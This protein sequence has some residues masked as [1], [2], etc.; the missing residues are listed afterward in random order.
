MTEPVQK[1]GNRLS[2]MEY[3]EISLVTRG[4]N[5]KAK[6]VLF[7]S[8]C[9]ADHSSMKA[10][11]TC[12]TCGH[13][14]GSKVRKGVVGRLAGLIK[15]SVDEALLDELE[16]TIHEQDL[17][18]D[19]LLGEPVHQQEKNMPDIE[20]DFIEGVDLSKLDDLTDEQKA[21]V[22]DVLAKAKAKVEE[23]TEDNTALTEAIDELEAQ[24]SVEEENEDDPDLTKLDELAKSDPALAEVISKMQADTAAAQAEA[25]A[26]I[27]KAEQ[28]EE[29][30][31]LGE[32]V[33]LAKQWTPT[34]SADPEALGLALRDI[35]KS[36]TATTY[37][38]IEQVIKSA[39][40]VAKTAKVLEETGS[41]G[42]PNPDSAIGKLDAAATE[43]RKAEPELSVEEARA[44]ALKDDPT[45]YREYR[46]EQSAK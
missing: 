8:D 46:A 15:G 7:K 33:T 4:A 10:G 17:D 22:N 19:T 31:K 2:G 18:P 28:M 5:Q 26:A 1:H 32:Q 16:E 39:D 14:V 36:C 43:I 24:F 9:P 41:A 37:A 11:E 21:A 42:V 40:T 3:D 20:A 27:E 23:V 30:A 12:P 35:A 29:I 45:L 38:T 6:I 13:K 44:K 25:K 34:I